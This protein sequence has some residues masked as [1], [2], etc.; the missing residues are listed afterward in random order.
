MQTTG[1]TR[2]WNGVRQ[3]ERLLPALEEGYFNVDEMSFED[4][5]T[6]SVEFASSLTYYNSNLQ[7]SGD[8]KAFLASNEIIIMA[9]IINKNVDEL[10]RSVQPQQSEGAATLLAIPAAASL[11]V[12]LDSEPEPAAVEAPR[13][14]DLDALFRLAE[15]LEASGQRDKAVDVYTEMVGMDP[16]PNPDVWLQAQVRLGLHAEATGEAEAAFSSISRVNSSSSSEP[17]LTPIRT[18]LP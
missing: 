3:N 15:R 2:I 13:A 11:L 1:A 7:P 8:W 12:Q 17:Q 18:G 6:A 4:L 10:R 5:L 16:T 9:C 14:A